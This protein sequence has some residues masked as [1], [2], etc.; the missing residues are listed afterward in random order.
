MSENSQTFDPSLATEQAESSESQTLTPSEENKLKLSSL[1][2]L[3]QFL[4]PYP[5]QVFIACAA[6]LFTAGITLGIGQG[7]RLVVD[8]GFAT[9]S[10]AQLLTSIQVLGLLALLM[11]IGVFIRFYMMSWLGER[12]SADIRQQ[13][14]DHLVQLHPS[15]FEL[16]RSGDIMSRLTTDTTLLQNIIGSSISMALR[17]IIMVIGALILLI[18]TNWK[19]T[20]IIFASVPF[21]FIPI[22]LF[23]KRVR[24]LSRDSQDSIADVGTYAGEIIQQI[25]TVQ[26]FT[27]EDQEKLAFG[28]EVTKAFDVARKRIAQRAFLIA[29]VI[30]MVFGGLCAMLWVGGNGVLNGVMSAGDL[31]AFGFYAFL[32][33][34]G[35]GTLSEAYSQILQA[36]GATDRLMQLMHADNEILPPAKVSHVAKDLSAELSIE[37]ISFHYPSRP[38]IP[39]LQNFSLDIP[40]GQTLALVGP[41]GAGKSTIFELLQRFYDPQQGSIR[42]GGTDIRELSPQDLRQQIAVVAQHPALFTADVSHNIRYGDSNA[43]DA[44]VIQAAKAA[45]AHEFIQQLPQGYESFLGE[46]GVRLSGG[47][48]QRIAIARAILK[49]PRILLLDEATSALDTESE[50]QVQQALEKLMENRT[51]VIIAHRLSTVL[52]ADTIAVMDEGKLVAQ[53]THDELIASN[54][55]YARLAELQFKSGS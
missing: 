28:V 3:L 15:F 14:F 27:R 52:H 12:V 34:S 7:L 21:I 33:A 51:T 35:M 42:F 5:K 37:N 38:E 31:T 50:Y 55:L 54:A 10:S 29:A 46:Q 20:L 13:V 30:L 18:I 16:N 43:S 36:I 8:S 2:K 6:L 39:A 32:V 40:N 26:S 19:L 53:G 49:N 24:K 41:S 11:T 45:Y 47:Q 9:G 25:K 22:L 4:K 48:K 44:Q 1:S 23:G 17:N